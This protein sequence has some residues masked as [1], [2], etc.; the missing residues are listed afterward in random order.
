M[1]FPASSRSAIYSML[2]SIGMMISLFLSTRLNSLSTRFSH[3]LIR[4]SAVPFLKSRPHENLDGNSIYF[5]SS[6]RMNFFPDSSRHPCHPSE[7]TLI[8]FPSY[9]TSSYDSSVKRPLSL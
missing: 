2:L 9:D 7:V 3:P 8:I 4:T 1:Q 5:P 6:D